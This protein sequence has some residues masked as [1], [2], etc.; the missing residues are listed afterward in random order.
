MTTFATSFYPWLLR[1][2]ERTDPLGALARAAQQDP[3]WPKRTDALARLDRYLAGRG[4]TVETRQAL[5]RAYGEWLIA[6]AG[7]LR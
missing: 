1:Q 3:A 6:T 2:A 5:R 7:E 4:A